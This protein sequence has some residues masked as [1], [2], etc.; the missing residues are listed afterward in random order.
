M[1][2]IKIIS[3]VLFNNHQQRTWTMGSH[4]FTDRKMVVLIPVEKSL[5]Q[6]FPTWSRLWPHFLKH[7]SRQFRQTQ[8]YL[9]AES[10]QHQM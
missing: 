3:G 8:F 2:H 9:K 5:G 1:A 10:I 7:F 4:I 6:L